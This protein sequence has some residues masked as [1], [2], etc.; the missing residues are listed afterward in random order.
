MNEPTP[1]SATP[2]PEPLEELQTSVELGDSDAA[3]AELQ[4]RFDLQGRGLRQHIASGVVINSMFQIGYAALG[5]V[6]RFS[7]AAFLTVSEYGFWGLLV[8]TLITLTWL[9]QVG[10]SDKYIQQDED[11]QVVAFQKA[12]TLEF[13]FSGLMFGLCAIALPVYAVVY[14]RPEIV[15]PG[16]VLS[17]AIILSA[18]EAPLWIPYRQMRFVRQRTLEAADPL[19]AIIV[20]IGLAVAGFGY[21][22][23][24]L[25]AVLGSLAGASVAV[26]T[27]PYPIAFKLE[28][29]TLREYFSFSWPL[30]VQSATGLIAVQGAIIVGNFTVGLVGLGAIALAT[31]FAAFADRV[32]GIIRQTMYPA[33]CAVKDRLDLLFET[34]VKSNRLAMMWGIPFGVGLALFAPDLVTYALGEKWRSAEPLIQVLGLVVGFRQIAFNWQVFLRAIGNTRPIAVDGAL[35]AA[36]FLLVTAPLMF[37]LGTTGFAIGVAFSNAAELAYRGYYMSR[38]FAGFNFVRHVTRA[39]APSVPA[40]AVVLAAR[41]IESGPRTP[42]I[43][44]AEALFY[45]AVT[46]AATWILERE[47]LTEMTDYM[48]GRRRVS[49]PPAPLPTS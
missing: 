10:I 2:A 31:N 6:R 28:R 5:L 4:S 45:G 8:T 32:D 20:T 25:G 33:V 16:L 14:G 38:L 37:V 3:R 9:K 35:V 15:A 22:S 43:A 23:L 26:A 48:R 13:A 47:L 49:T 30:F 11:D 19:V 46:A 36:A 40:L 21:W 41:T 29:G 7:V 42:G 18:L 24:V 1:N 44:I 27:C 17:S 39:V 34:F 12:F